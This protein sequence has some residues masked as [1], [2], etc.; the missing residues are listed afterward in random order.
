LPVEFAET[1]GVEKERLA[2]ME[3]FGEWKFAT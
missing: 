2:W 3:K 1:Q